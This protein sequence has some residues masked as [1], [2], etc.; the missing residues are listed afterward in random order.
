[1]SCY[2]RPKSTSRLQKPAGEKKRKKNPRLSGADLGFY[3]GGCPIHLKGAP[4]VESRRRRGAGDCAPSP[5]N[6]C[7]SHI[8]MVSFY[9]FPV[10]FIDT[11]LFRK[12]ALIKRVGVRTP[13]TPPGSGPECSCQQC[14][15]PVLV[16]SVCER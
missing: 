4:E 10:I 11:V 16:E 7:I 8:K 6:F 15:T 9:A 13:W 14:R 3:K 1:M 12:G 2:D 5:E